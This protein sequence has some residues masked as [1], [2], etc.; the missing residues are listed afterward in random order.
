MRLR[1]RGR[2]AQPAAFLNGGVV[3]P[4]LAVWIVCSCSP[5]FGL[6]DIEG[7]PQITAERVV[8]AGLVAYAVLSAL[9]HRENVGGIV[10]SEVVLWVLAGVA[11]VSGLVFGGFS[12]GYAGSGVSILFNFILFPAVVYSIVLRTRWSDRDLA[13]CCVI[14]TTFGA[15]LG[16]TAILER[17]HFTALLIPPDIGDPSILQHWGRSRGPF[18]QAEFNGTVMT[19]LLPVAALLWVFRGR[20]SGLLTWLAIPLLCIGVYLTE[21][22]AALLSLALIVLFGAVRRHPGRALYGVLCVALGLVVGGLA[23]GG[24]NVIPRMDESSPLP[25]RLNLLI[26]TA[27]MIAAHPVLGVGFGNFDSY[28]EEFFLRPQVLANLSTTTRKEFWAGG[29]HNTLLTPIAELGMAAGGLYL[30]IVLWGVFRAWR[31]PSMAG[32]SRL[33]GGVGE[34]PMC[35]FLIGV[36]FIVNAV[37]VELRFSLTPHALLWAFIALAQR[38]RI[39]AAQVGHSGADGFA[40][41]VPVSFAHNPAPS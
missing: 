5:W 8:F 13:R 18:L 2:S 36:T 10:P 35:A 11:T 20:L 30:A 7:L 26:A 19:Q 9:K 40:S 39:S 33:K 6:P 38:H 37:F 28:Q 24:T 14:L 23:A 16:C 17:T 41:F 27:G 1:L 32:G 34:L 31:T 21:T 25:D 12:S 3:L 15:Y 22:R 4:W 29:T